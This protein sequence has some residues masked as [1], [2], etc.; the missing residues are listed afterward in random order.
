[1]ACSLDAKLL[2]VASA[3]IMQSADPHLECTHLS[4]SRG[5]CR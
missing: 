3:C 2:Q 1:M 5:R 4:S